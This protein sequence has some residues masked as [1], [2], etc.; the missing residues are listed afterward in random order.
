MSRF[1]YQDGLTI[2]TPVKQGHVDML[3][4]SLADIER[5]IEGNDFI[6][7]REFETIHF[8]RWVLFE[9]STDA[10]G[11]PV[12]AQLVL[13]TNFDEPVSGHLNEFF[14]KGFKGL[15]HVYRHCKGYPPEGQRSREQVLQY[16][17]SHEV[18][19]G[20]LYVGTRGRSMRQ[21]RREALLRD[22][23]QDFLDENISR[24]A[25]GNQQPEEIRKAIQKFVRSDPDLQWAEN[26][27]LYHHRRWTHFRDVL[28]FSLVILVGLLPML[29]GILTTAMV[30]IAIF[31]ILVA[32]GVLAIWTLQR[33]EKRD[34]QYPADTDYN[35]VHNLALRE[36][37]IVQNQMSSVTNVK[38]GWFRWVLLSTVLR[39]I[40]IAGRYIYTEGKLGSIPS[41]HYARWVMID[42]GSRL[43]FFSNFDGSWENYLGD[44]ID[45]AA[46][47]LTAVWSNT[48]GF[49]RSR[50]LIGEGAT[51]EQRFKAYARNSQVVTNVWYSAYKRLS[52][53]NIN[54]NSHIRNGLFGEQ[55]S[56]QTETWLQRL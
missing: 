54:N 55:S 21:I 29:A 24:I 1:T 4:A 56:E 31:A 10:R 22:R 53:Q 18:G 25:F 37:R 6:P 2:V 42:G 48:H 12:P 30:G 38:P 3:R 39:A 32:A 46:T 33:K 45:K 26:Q 20:T 17:I 51:D 9:A 41:I 44:F 16:L 11:R 36:D 23:I 28:P 13:S 7:F 27:E 34:V 5:D 52:V 43:L 19:Y 35:Q 47:G 15:N 14:D 40:D 50:W 49:P 8:A